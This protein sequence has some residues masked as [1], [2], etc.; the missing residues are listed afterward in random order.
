MQTE[1]EPGQREGKGQTSKG[2]QGVSASLYH[3]H[4]HAHQSEPLDSVPMKMK[5]QQE[6]GQEGKTGKL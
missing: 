4:P 1:S 3:L 6:P 2:S 5:S